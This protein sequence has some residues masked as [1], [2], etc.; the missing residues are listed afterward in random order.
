M[1]ES[2]FIEFDSND[3]L[4][5]RFI[6]KLHLKERFFLLNNVMSRSN[7]SIYFQFD[8]VYGINFRRHHMPQKGGAIQGSTIY[9]KVRMY[10][11][12]LYGK[13]NTFCKHLH[14]LKRGKLQYYSNYILR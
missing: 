7:H 11:L 13:N 1:F 6:S 12:L 5:A 9:V 14:V 10:G 3:S 2:D 4:Y 8:M